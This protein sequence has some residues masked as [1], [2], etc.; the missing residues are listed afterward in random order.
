MYSGDAWFSNNNDER[1]KYRELQSLT[2]WKKTF[3]SVWAELEFHL[4][5]KSINIFPAK[6]ARSR[7]PIC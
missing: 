7:F 4:A 3:S 2:G 6:I 1:E 5:D